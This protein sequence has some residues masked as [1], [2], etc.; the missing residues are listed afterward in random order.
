[1]L[2]N[3]CP[4]TDIGIYDQC[5]EYLKELRKRTRLNNKAKANPYARRREWLPKAIR[6]QV[7]AKYKYKCRYCGRSAR[8]VKTHV[9]HVVPL[10]RGG[11]D[12]IE[13]LCLACVECN[14]KKSNKTWTAKHGQLSMDS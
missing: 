14:L 2:H 10:S 8:E 5:R 1:M 12:D 3:L 7:A 6:C 11:T 13:N 9:D 4:Y